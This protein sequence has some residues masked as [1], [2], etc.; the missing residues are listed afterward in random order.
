MSHKSLKTL[1][2]RAVRGQAISATPLFLLALIQAETTDRRPIQE[3]DDI[4][5]HLSVTGAVA[6]LGDVADVG[7]GKDVGQRPERVVGIQGFLVEDIQTC[8]SDPSFAEGR[9]EGGII[10]QWAACCVDQKGAR[11]HL[12]DGGVIHDPPRSIGE[13]QM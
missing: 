7:R 6:A 5:N 4:L 3:A 12:P 11:L 9:D 1:A 2:V 13:H 8:A 10:H